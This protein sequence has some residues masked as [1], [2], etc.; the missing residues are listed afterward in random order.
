MRLNFNVLW[1]DDQP[2]QLNSQIETITREM[3][4]QGFEFKA[5]IR[6]SIPEVKELI[7]DDVFKDEVDLILVDWDL[8]NGLHG[9]D[10]IA[11]VREAIQYKDVV[12]YS[13][14]T[15]ATE[16]REMAF[17]VGAEGIFCAAKNDIVDEV[18]GVF[19]A[20]VKKV[21]DLD[22]TRGIVMG[23]TSDIDQMVHECLSGIHD[24][25]DAVGK[26]KLL[27][28][29]KSLVRETIKD[30]EK[31]SKKL[32]ATTDMSE[33]LAAYDVLQAYDRLRMVNE[34][35]KDSKYDDHDG[36]R[37]NLQAYMQDGI[38]KRNILGHLVLQPDGRPSGIVTS[39][40]KVVKIEDMLGLRIFLLDLRSSVRQ[41]RDVVVPKKA[42]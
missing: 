4:R 38:K 10:V 9:Q 20:L 29:A 31:K 3:H 22:H 25:E 19:E 13:S 18:L 33:L 12:F 5:T 24:T 39:D 26:Q 21:L 15:T 35:L 41:F 37:G 27:D 30:L 34:M 17:K 14:L 7:A 40:G 32:E 2:D 36:L 42:G 1:V 11:Q 23:A 16:L 6:K 8:G 28:K